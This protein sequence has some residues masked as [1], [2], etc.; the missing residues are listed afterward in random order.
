MTMSAVLAALTSV[1]TAVEPMIELAS[2]IS[3]E[4][5]VSVPVTT[6][7]IALHLYNEQQYLQQIEQDI[8]ERHCV[9]MRYAARQI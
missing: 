4:V 1:T 2:D 6:E 5:L 8:K 7:D 9:R 3:T